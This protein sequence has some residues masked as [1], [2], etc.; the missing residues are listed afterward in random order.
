M[1]CDIWI[2]S[3]RR[4]ISS[5]QIDFTEEQCEKK[6]QEEVKNEHKRKLCYNRQTTMENL[7]YL[8][9]EERKRKRKRIV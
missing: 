2:K 4:R 8:T 9:N 5:A 6:M 1:C 7:Q 3:I